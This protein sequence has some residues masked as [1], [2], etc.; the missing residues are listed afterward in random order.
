MR[1]RI[2]A[3]RAVVG[4]RVISKTGEGLGGWLV[5]IVPADVSEQRFRT[6]I[7]SVRAAPD[8]SF[9]VSGA[10]GEYLIVARNES[11]LSGMLTPEFFQRGM[12]DAQRLTLKP[13][14]QS[15]DVKIEGQ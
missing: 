1:I 5:L 3:A 13:G 2:S 15:F 6:P 10:P 12:P 4:G 14:E 8:G 9:R 7:L 11:E